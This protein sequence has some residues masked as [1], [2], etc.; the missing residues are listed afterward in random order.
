[1]VSQDNDYWSGLNPVY[2]VMYCS[3]VVQDES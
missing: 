2:S 3:D 1:M